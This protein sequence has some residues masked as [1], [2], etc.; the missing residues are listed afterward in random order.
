MGTQRD[1]RT[2]IGLAFGGALPIVAAAAL[3][4]VRGHISNTNVALALTV[5]VVAAGALFGRGAGVMA[6][7]T[8]ALSFNFFH[9]RPYLSLRI[10]SGDDIE[11]TFLLLVVGLAS[12]HLAWRARVAAERLAGGRS[13]LARIRRLADQVARGFE[14]T[15]VIMA[16]R[17]ELFDMLALQDC[18]FEAVPFTDRLD[19]PRLERDGTIARMHYR[20]ER[21]G[22][23]ELDLPAEGLVLPVLA[24][25]QLVGRLVLDPAPGAAASLEER[26][27]AIALADQVGA[28]L[29]VYPPPLTTR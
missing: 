22:V 20:A 12:G 16:A 1:A 24:R 23:L 15:D 8:A 6:A 19:L 29:A 4:G 9:T 7:V 27:V 25:G 26:I 3:V 28:S 14:T 13:E 21:N 17:A 18:R 10:N 11:T 2:P 5:T